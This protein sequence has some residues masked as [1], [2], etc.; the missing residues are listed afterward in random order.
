MNDR[1]LLKPFSSKRIDRA[2][3]S[4]LLSGLYIDLAGF[5]DPILLVMSSFM[6]LSINGMSVSNFILLI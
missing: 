5:L 6:C 4:G 1:I 2:F 3:P